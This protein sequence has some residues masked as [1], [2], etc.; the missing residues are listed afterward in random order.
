M[1]NGTTTL[2]EEQLRQDASEHYKAL[3]AHGQELYKKSVGEL[4][5]AASD[6]S[7]RSEL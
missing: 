6:C 2:E 7:P 4:V 1:K 5:W 3:D